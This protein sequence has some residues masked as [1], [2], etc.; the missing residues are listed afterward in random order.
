MRS[1]KLIA[2]GSEE[3]KY[4]IGHKRRIQLDGDFYNNVSKLGAKIV[5]VEIRGKK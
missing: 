4:T 5:W 1:Q 2:G 3:N